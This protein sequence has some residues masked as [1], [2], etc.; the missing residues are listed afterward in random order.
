M[1]IYAYR[2]IKRIALL[3][4]YEKRMFMTIMKSDLSPSSSFTI[5]FVT[6]IPDRIKL[7]EIIRITD[8]L[9]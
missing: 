4:L 1:L 3:K 8:S 6:L 7:V 5:M 2:K 9:I